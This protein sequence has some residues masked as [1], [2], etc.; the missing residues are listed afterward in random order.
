MTQAQA[1]SD[2]S[3]K[4]LEQI[5]DEIG[6]ASIKER[7]VGLKQEVDRFTKNI[8]L[9]QEGLAESKKRFEVATKV[10]KL[11][12]KGFKK[13]E[14][15]YEYEA[16]P[17]YWE[18]REQEI[19]FQIEDNEKQFAGQLSMAEARLRDSL[20]SRESS[21]KQLNED[22]DKLESLGVKLDE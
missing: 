9:I 16:D 13:I 8:E 7:V 20:A 11:V 17:A 18:L 4:N 22:L 19:K 5:N 3:E 15:T 1:A 6:I 10:Q 21:Q 14:P 12:L 2:G